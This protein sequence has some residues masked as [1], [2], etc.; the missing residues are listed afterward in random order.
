[1]TLMSRKRWRMG[2][3]AGFSPSGFKSLLGRLDHSFEITFAFV[4]F[5]HVARSIKNANHGVM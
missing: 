2:N 4:C 5:N 1:M 3:W